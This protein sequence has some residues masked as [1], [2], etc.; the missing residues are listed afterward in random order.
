MGSICP[1]AFIEIRLIE[2][3]RP[4]DVHIVETCYLDRSVSTAVRKSNFSTT[5]LHCGDLGS[6]VEA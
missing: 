6:A 3:V 5:I 4:R 1:P 2:V